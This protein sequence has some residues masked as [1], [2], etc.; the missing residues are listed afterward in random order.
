MGSILTSCEHDLLEALS[1]GASSLELLDE[2]QRQSFGELDSILG[3][4][5]EPCSREEATQPNLAAPSIE[6]QLQDRAQLE[7]LTRRLSMLGA[8][9]VSHGEALARLEQSQQQLESQQQQQQQQ[10]QQV[11]DSSQHTRFAASLEDLAGLDCRSDIS[12]LRHR[13]DD[14]A[15]DCECHWV[16]IDKKFLDLD[17][18][19]S[20]GQSMARSVRAGRSCT[21]ESKRLQAKLS[22][23]LALDT[24]EAASEKLISAVE[25]CA[26]TST[27]EHQTSSCSANE[28]T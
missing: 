15:K 6:S 2:R 16:H 7:E 10:L 21:A 3:R 25:C 27:G 20:Q 5:L 24:M 1:A 19:A 14:L 11:S 8:A 18:K 26:T 23:M 9:I 4:T 12:N 28:A 22:T 17:L 13:L